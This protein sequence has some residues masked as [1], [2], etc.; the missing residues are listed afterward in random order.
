MTSQR[1]S[2]QIE[3]CIEDAAFAEITAA[4]GADRIELCSALDLGGLTPTPASVRKTKSAGVPF[5]AMVRIRDGDFVLDENDIALMRDEISIHIE[6]GA[7]GIVLGALTEEGKVDAVALQWLVEACQGRPVT[8]HRA[9]DHCVDRVTGLEQIIDCGCQRL[10]TS[11]GAETA[12]EGVEEISRIVESSAGRI[13][14]IAGGGIRP[15]SALQL[16]EKTELRW[17]HLSGRRKICGPSTNRSTQI[18]LGPT[19]SVEAGQRWITDPSII[20]ALREELNRGVD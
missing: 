18:P 5:N 19:T 13:E 7:S 10:L 8:F 14:V 9:F 15:G 6:N 2:V 17:L 11:G 12:M 1:I 16:V 4:A 3:V 20:R